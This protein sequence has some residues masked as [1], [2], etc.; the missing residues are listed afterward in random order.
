M[1]VITSV[2]FT[3][4]KRNVFL[5]SNK[6]KRVCFIVNIVTFKGYFII[7]KWVFNKR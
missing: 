7:G 2:S 3:Y 4:F 6:H 1:H 5:K